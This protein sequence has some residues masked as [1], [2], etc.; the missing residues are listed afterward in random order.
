MNTN[1]AYFVT[2]PKMLRSKDGNKREKIA[3]IT[4][5]M[6]FRGAAAVFKVKVT[7][8]FYKVKAHKSNGLDKFEY[9]LNNAVKQVLTETMDY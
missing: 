2:E 7:T 1:A 3:V 4:E 5:S 9:K 8:L 6:S